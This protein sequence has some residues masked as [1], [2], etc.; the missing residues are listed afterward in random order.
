[1]KA[2]YNLATMYLNGLGVSPDAEK[3]AFWYGKAAEAGHGPSMY[4]LGSLFEEGRGV[5][6]DYR[7]AAGWYEAADVAA[8]KAIA[9]TA[10]KKA[11]PLRKKSLVLPADLK[12]TASGNPAPDE[13][14]PAGSAMP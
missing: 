13:A 8:K 9:E 12:R 11:G 5:K 4:R 10:G 7:R 3:A 2:Q 14:E 6:R 1:M